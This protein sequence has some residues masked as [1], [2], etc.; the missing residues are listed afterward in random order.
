MRVAIL[1]L[2]AA[3]LF[4]SCR[5]A[6][7]TPPNSIRAYAGPDGLVVFESPTARFEAAPTGAIAAALDQSGHSTPVDAGPLPDQVTVDGA[8]VTFSAQPESVRVYDVAGGKAAEVRTLSADGRLECRR[9]FELYAAFPGMLMSTASFVNHS[10]APLAL[11]TAV[12]NAHRVPAADTWSF[13]GASE[14]WGQDD[15]VHLQP[16]L[17]RANRVGASLADGNGGGLPVAAFWTRHGGLAIGHLDQ[18]PLTL[19]MPLEV[20]A[21]GDARVSL[22]YA[23]NVTL[24]NAESYSTPRQF[25]L[26]YSGDYYDALRAYSNA[27][28]HDGWTPAKPPDEAYSPTW[29]GWGYL[30]NVTPSQMLG[31]IPKLKQY[32]IHWATLDDRWFDAYGDWNPRPDTFPGNK[33]RDMVAQYHQNGIKVQLWWLP[34]GAELHGPKDDSHAYVDSNVARTHPDWLVLDPQGKPALMTRELA[35]LCPALPEVQQYYKQLTTRFIRDWDFDGHKLDNI[36]SVPPC[37]NPKHHHRSP[38]DSVNAMADVY[39]IIW[40]TSRALKPDSVTQTCPCGTPPNIA[41]LPYLDQ[42]VTA[43]PVGSIQ[44][45]RRIKM[46]KALLGDSA[47]V[48]GDHVELTELEQR[49]DREIDFGR[50]FASTVGL[51]GVVGTKFVWPQTDALYSD[52]VLTREKDRQWQHWFEIYGSKMLS[53]GE[54]RNLYLTGFDSPEGYVIEKDGVMNYAFF[55]PGPHGHFDGN[56]T[57]RG[58]APGR[59]R[60]HDYVNG[61][62]LATVDASQPTFPASFD[63]S[64]LFEALRQ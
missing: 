27:L 46:Y 54:F 5:T 36:F 33:L 7:P 3:A 15:V 12:T 2:L 19:S 14:K 30:A 57:L 60:L 47:P 50:D 28:R 62:D 20:G 26:A 35:T 52:V 56:I 48:Y 63:G 31:I 32:H 34:L 37:Y 16:G 43:D 40:E 9:V 53:R 41:W 1:L 8:Q 42:A 39:K 49:K 25:T 21:S 29:C 17:K 51:G 59:Y 11:Q 4:T 38:Q 64:L 61:R 23:P 10:A 6:P 58:L 13:L 55:T 24:R 18:R 22:D 45:R 44:V